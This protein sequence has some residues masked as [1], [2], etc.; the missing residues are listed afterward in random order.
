MT[1]KLTDNPTVLAAALAA[2]VLATPAA[3][4]DAVTDW[5]QRAIDLVVASGLGNQPAH[6]VLAITHTAALDAAQ[7]AARSG[8]PGAV[9]AAIAAAHCAAL[10]RLLPSQQAAVDAVCRPLLAA[11]P[12][13]PDAAAAI[14]LGERAARDVLAR[15]A[16]DGAAAPDTYRPFTTPG[17]YVPTA[18]PAAPHWGQRRPWLMSAPTQFRP[19][20][21]PALASERWARDYQEVAA[22]GGP[23]SSARSAEQT[24][25]A[26]FWQT[27]HPAIYHAALRGVAEQPGRDV[28]RNARLFAAFTQ[29]IDDAMIAVFDAKYHHAFWRPITAIRNG[30]ADGHDA[31]ERDA[32]WV[33]LIATPMHPE[34]PCAHCVQAGVLGA[35][36]RAEL[37]STLPAPVL[38]TR[39]P[40]AN[41]ATRRWT[42]V[43][44][45]EQEVADARVW[46]GLHYRFST[47]A[48]LEMGR[49]I[50]ALAVQRHLDP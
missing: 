28:L 42:S 32:G 10:T 30:D 20:P 14:E 18:M 12:G 35:V 23:R 11:Q 2:A 1:S 6:R 3:L 24:E 21:P 45:L 27:T 48:G 16:D 25:V 46:G 49:A 8:P 4:A 40:S 17:R 19:A 7:A 33:P 9:P 13:G 41:G 34:Y 5:N 38:A 15:R 47:E 50:G 43:Q 44:A 31:T 36:L 22:F 39:S 37:G 29:A 26:R